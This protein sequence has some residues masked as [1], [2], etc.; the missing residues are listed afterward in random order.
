LIRSQ[1]GCV[2]ARR[3]RHQQLTT[4][5]QPTYMHTVTAVGAERRY[6]SASTCT[7]AYYVRAGCRRPS[8]ASSQRQ[9]AAAFLHVGNI[10]DGAGV[11]SFSLDR[12][13]SAKPG[14]SLL[15]LLLARRGNH[16]LCRFQVCC[17]RRLSAWIILGKLEHADAQRSTNATAA[18]GSQPFRQ[19]DRRQYTAHENTCVHKK[20]CKMVTGH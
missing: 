5:R 15:L 12:S 7:C 9:R 20:A 2:N 6:S 14:P 17:N 19:S 18:E 4:S 3:G 11:E 8:G 16:F 13:S 1:R 10:L